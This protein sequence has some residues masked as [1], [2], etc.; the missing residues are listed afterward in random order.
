MSGFV[1]ALIAWP[2]LINIALVLWLL[3]WTSKPRGSE[4]QAETTGHVWDG[5]L[6]ELNKPL[7]RW[8]MGLFILTVVFGL[9]YLALYPGL[10]SF[11]GQKNWTQIEQYEAQ[12][13]QAEAVLARTFAPYEKAPLA[14]LERNSSALHIGRNLFL[15]NCAGCH[16]SGEGRR[17]FQISPTRT[18]CGVDSRRRCWRPFRMDAWE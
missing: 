12:S 1:S 6:Q 16:G 8:W 13:R 10:G 17:D 5:D 15:N 14:D 7:P 2:T 18:G 3:W 11:R 9:V 4:K